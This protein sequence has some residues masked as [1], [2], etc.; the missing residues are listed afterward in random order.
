MI[1]GVKSTLVAID[2]VV[3]GYQGQGYEIVG[4]GW[5]QGHKDSGA[6]NEVYEKNLVNLIN[7]VRK[8]LNAPKMKAV[9]ATVGFHGYRISNL[10]WWGIWQAQMAVGDPKQH[11][12]FAGNVA[13]VDTRDFWREVAESP[14]NQDYHYNRSGET[15][16]LVGEAMGRAMVRL[17]GGEAAEIP[18]SDREARTAAAMAAE[19]AAPVPSD[20]QKAANRVAIQP[21]ILESS[22]ASH[23]SNERN[24]AMI[25]DAIAGKKAAK[26]TIFLDDI[27]DEAVQFYQAAGVRDYDWKPLGDDLRQAEWEYF[28]Y[29]LPGRPGKMNI[30]N[31]AAARDEGEG[32]DDANAAA[33]KPPAKPAEAVP[34]KMSIPAGLENWFAPDFDTAKA[35]FKTG[36][37]PFGESA[38]HLVL[39]EWAQAR[40][41]KRVPKT[42]LD[43]DV[44]LLRKTVQLPPL[45]D[46]YRYRIRVAGS[47]HNNMGEGFAIYVNG[48]LLV[49]NEGGLFAWRRQ[50]RSPRG[51][52]IYPELRELFKDGKVT[53]AVSN[54]PMNDW[55]P[56]RFVPP[57]QPVSVWIEQ[58][59]IPPI[60]E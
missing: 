58:Q 21:F 8:D 27:I 17:E 51:A 48:Q 54:Y 13:S 4:F 16:M 42:V 3:P 41:A 59:K 47:A 31:F 19:A 33:P 22:L 43:H 60:A 18:K 57:G 10:P 49:Q 56:G 29:D 53:L 36:V 45:Q 30:S 44:I 14:R 34:V 6:P 32:D 20:E 50:G 15:Y 55:E 38:E 39:P 11:P 52:S 35:G 37:G 28:A 25:K 5:F 9:V 7:D 1:E 23:V 2:K 12:E 24:R 40:V 26:P 46:G